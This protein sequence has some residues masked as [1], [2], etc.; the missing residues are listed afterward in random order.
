MCPARKVRPSRRHKQSRKWIIAVS[1]VLLSVLLLAAAYFWYPKNSA[2]SQQ[3]S[4]QPSAF[5]IFTDHYVSVMQNLNSTATKTEMASLLN[6]SYNQTDL[7]AWEKTK[8]TFAQDP[9][10]FYED[11]SQ[12]LSSGDGICVQWS[13]VYVSACLAL[14]HP[15]RLVVAAN[16]ASWSFIHTWAEDY[17]NGS[18]VHVDPSDAVWNDPSHY[19][20]W[21]WGAAI[22]SGVRIYAFTDSGFQDVTSNYMPN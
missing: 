4:N 18:W 12:I 22:G 13:I 6:P 9:T 11:P 14:N 5:Q 1:A 2:D 20:G 17:Y 15:S 10:G 7:F 19:Q 21:D 16:T 8:L 3:E